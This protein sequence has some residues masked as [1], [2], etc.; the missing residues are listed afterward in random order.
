MASYDRWLTKHGQGAPDDPRPRVPHDEAMACARAAIEAAKLTLPQSHSILPIL[1]SAKA[2]DE[3]AV[4]TT[5]IVQISARAAEILRR[6]IDDSVSMLSEDPHAHRSSRIPGAREFVVH[7]G[8]VVLYRVSPDHIEIVG[9]LHLT[10]E[11][12]K[13]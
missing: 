2:L 11:Y 4:I 8:Y 12:P 13:G 5:N 3:L 10:P 6:L 7:P 9:V 1:W